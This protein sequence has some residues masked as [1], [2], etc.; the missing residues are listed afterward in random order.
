MNRENLNNQYKEFGFE[1]EPKE[2]SYYINIIRANLVPVIIIFVISVIVTYIYVMNQTSIYKATS[3]LQI[4]NPQGNILKAPIGEFGEL[5]SDRYINNQIQILKSFY[6]RDI[7]AK[8]LL[9]SV[10]SNSENEYFVYSLNKHFKYIVDRIS[11]S[12]YKP[13]SSETLRLRLIKIMDFEQERDMDVVKIIVEGPSFMENQLIANTYASVYVSYSKESNRQDIKNVKEYLEKE[14]KKKFIELKESE[15]SLESFQERTGL[16]VLDV[17]AQDLINKISQYDAERNSA[18]IEYRANERN[19]STLK[20]E[21]E[22]VDSELY[23][24]VERQVNQPYIEELQRQIAEIEVKR[25]IETAVVTDQKVV[26]RI[27]YDAE[28]KVNKLKEN[29]DE[30]VQVLRAGILSETPEEIRDLTGRILNAKLLSQSYRVKSNLLSPM[31]RRYEMEFSRLPSESIELA[32]L[33]RDRTSTEKLYLILEEKYQEALINERARLGNATILDPGVENIGKVKPNRSLIMVIGSLIGLSLGFVYAIGRNYLDKS[34]KSPEEL[35]QK[36]VSILSWI[37]TI[38]SLKDSA[39]SPKMN[40]IVTSQSKD[41]TSESFKAL[42]TRIQYSKLGTKSLKSILVTSTLPTE[43]K[44]FISVNLAGSFA[45]TDKKVLLLDCDL[46]KPRVHSIF[47][48]ERF[49]G[50]SDYLFAK[51]TYEEIVRKTQ[52]ENMSYITSGTIPPNPSE[53]LGSKQMGEFFEFLKGKFDLIVVDS[54]PFISV[55]DSEILFN[56]TDGTVLIAQANKTPLDVYVKT[57]EKLRSIN[58]HNL[59][60]CVLNDFS[61]RKAYGYYYNYYYYYSKPYEREKSKIK[62]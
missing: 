51:V 2:L 59:L 53:L 33:E 29:L 38:E 16:I 57:Y 24:Y 28:Q 23:D 36:G 19:V 13:I 17:Q 11:K 44:T 26:D 46:R 20:D 40:F 22:N 56:V 31:V 48:T 42:R 34:I 39:L 32:R 6:I 12:E 1:E 49:P 41:S 47:E 25:D 21:I 10:K 7:V 4:E 5:R 55:T 45:I 3:I 58:P 14:K 62:N 35:E 52:L 50:L 9:D 60:G 27:K 30:K 43:G 18:E 37:P 8:A 15:I 61:Y 54:P